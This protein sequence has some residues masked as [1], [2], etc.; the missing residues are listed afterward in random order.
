MPTPAIAD[1]AD[2]LA[3]YRDGGLSVDA[4]LGDVGVDVGA[5]VGLHVFRIVEEGLTNVLRHS[6]ASRAWVRL[7]VD[8]G[9]LHLTVDDD[10]RGLVDADHHA[11]HGLIGIA[12][13]VALHG[14]SSHLG[15]SPHGGCRLAVSIPIP[16]AAATPAAAPSPTKGAER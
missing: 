1:L 10:G 5:P 9:V 13:R 12:E 4:E 2:L 15:P 7:R 3:S 11:G 14:G 6:H 8:D 16:P